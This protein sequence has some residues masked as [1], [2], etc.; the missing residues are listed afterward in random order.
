[1]YLKKRLCFANL[2]TLISKLPFLYGFYALIYYIEID[3]V[4][5]LLM[6]A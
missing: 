5:R 2:M 3:I 6:N 1:M 4:Y